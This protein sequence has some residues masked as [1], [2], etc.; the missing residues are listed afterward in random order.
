LDDAIL[1][2]H[3]GKSDSRGSAAQ[4]GV[5]SVDDA[6]VRELKAEDEPCQLVGV[7]RTEPKRPA[8]LNSFLRV[9]RSKTPGT[10]RTSRQP[11]DTYGAYR[12]AAAPPTA[13]PLHRLRAVELVRAR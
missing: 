6:A 2:P 10:L 12:F 5:T 13:T 8:H 4:P 1:R 9:D 7:N 11:G 3:F